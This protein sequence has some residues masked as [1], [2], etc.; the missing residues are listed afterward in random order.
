MEETA[1]NRTRS[2]ILPCLL[3]GLLAAFMLQVHPFA[4]AVPFRLQVTMHSDTAGRA[5]LIW[6]YEKGAALP[7]S[8]MAIVSAGRQVLS[9][10]LQDTG[11]GAFRVD[12]DTQDA[13][14]GFRLNPLDRAGQVA[15]GTAL[16]INPQ[17]EI[18]ARIPAPSLVPAR[19]DLSMK[20]A[21]GM[22]AF[23]TQPGDGIL[24][25][26]ARPLSLTRLTMPVEPVS[27]ALQFCGAALAMWLVLVL[28]GRVST[29]ARTRLAQALLKM[30]DDLAARP[31]A[32]IFCAAL[33]ATAASCHPV[34]F[35]GRS[36]VSPNNG[37]VPTLHN[38]FPE[39]V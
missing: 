11:G 31:A 22:A 9:F 27:A 13:I 15:I 4:P 26:P 7:N 19:P 35:F 5:R 14:S 28:A 8:D 32:V 3:I 2:R 33:L 38:T 20:I 10:N 21:G 17:G 39:L 36:H 6:R 24:M 25:K 23:A 37:P 34:I 18:V 16:V 30:R 29:D 1:L 12:A